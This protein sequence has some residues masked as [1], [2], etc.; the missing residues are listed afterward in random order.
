[1][2]IKPRPGARLPGDS[3]CPRVAKRSGFE[4]AVEHG[5]DISDQGPAFLRNRNG[6]PV[7]RDDAVLRQLVDGLY[8]R[9]EAIS[10]AVESRCDF[11]QIDLEIAHEALDDAPAQAV[12]VRQGN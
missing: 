3:Q 5:A 12:L 6:Q 10:V 9:L 11:S 7:S 1:M 8:L 4:I 2:H